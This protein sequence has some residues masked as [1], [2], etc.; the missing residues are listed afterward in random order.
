MKNWNRSFYLSRWFL[1]DQPHWYSIM[2]RAT[3]VRAFWLRQLLSSRGISRFLRPVNKN[4]AKFVLEVQARLSPSPTPPQPVLL[5]SVTKFSPPLPGAHGPPPVPDFRP[6]PEVWW[7]GPGSGKR[8][9]AGARTPLWPLPLSPPRIAVA[10]GWRSV[11]RRV[12]AGLPRTVRAA[13]FPGPP[14]SARDHVYSLC[15]FLLLFVFRRWD[16]RSPLPSPQLWRDRLQG[17]RGGGGERGQSLKRWPEP[18]TSSA[19]SQLL[20]RLPDPSVSRGPPGSP[21]T[22]QRSGVEQTPCV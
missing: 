18:G 17:D 14:G 22:P 19:W 7:A 3:S 13:A 1:K 8:S 21:H 5:C 11:R 2:L 10:P 9:G 16:D 4:L 6:E 15:R 20:R 12:G